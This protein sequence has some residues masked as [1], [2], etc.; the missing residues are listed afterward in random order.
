MCDTGIFVP[1][2]VRE[3]VGSEPGLMTKKVEQLEQEEIARVLL[4]YKM[5]QVS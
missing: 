2:D 5:S 1:V 3:R 4:L